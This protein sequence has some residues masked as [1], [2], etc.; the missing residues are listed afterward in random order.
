MQAKFTKKQQHIIYCSVLEQY[1]K[2]NK[3][4]NSLFEEYSTFKIDTNVYEYN[5]KMLRESA[6]EYKEILDELEMVHTV[7]SFQYQLT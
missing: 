3:R 6:A 2:I 5:M 4:I 1:S 7:N